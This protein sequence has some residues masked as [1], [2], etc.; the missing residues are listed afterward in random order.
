MKKTIAY[1]AFILALITVLGGI[2]LGVLNTSGEINFEFL[3]SKLA[4]TSVGFAFGFAGLIGAVYIFRKIINKE[5]TDEKRLFYVIVKNET[6]KP[7]NDV[8]V[9]AYLK[10]KTE[11][12]KTVTGSASFNYSQR[13]DNENIEVRVSKK[14]YEPLNKSFKLKDEKQIS[15]TLKKK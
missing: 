2:G 3:G 11:T 14:N 13:F 8:E 9:V 6:G 10:P 15:F 7:L 12:V 5:K 1:L 4:A